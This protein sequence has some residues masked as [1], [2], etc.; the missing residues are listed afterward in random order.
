MARS[1]RLLSPVLTAVLVLLIDDLHGHT[2]GHYG[3]TTEPR[4][5][6]LLAFIALI[7][8]T[9]YAA[10]VNESAGLSNGARLVRSVGAVGSAVVIIAL[11][12]VIAVALQSHSA[13]AQH[14]YVPTFDLGLTVVF[15]APGLTVLASA[16]HRSLTI[17]GQQERVI[18]LVGDEERERLLR[19]VLRRPERPS[20]VAAT[21]APADVVPAEGRAAPLEEAIRVQRITLIVMN[22]EAQALDD[23]V[24]QA[25]RAHAQGVRIRTLSLYY[26]EWLG[27][28]PLSELER[29]ALLFD[30]NEIHRP[31]Y[32][33]GKRFLDVVLAIA[34]LPVLLVAMPL[35]ALVNLAGN[36]G[37]LF[38]HQE[39][40]G[41]DGTIFTIH[42]F[43]TMRPSDAPSSWTAPD[44]DRISAVG[45]TLR[46]LHVDELPQVWNVLR[47]ELSIVGPRP[48]Q[49][50]Y[51][52]QLSEVIPFYDT[53]HLVRPGI[54]GWAQVK[55]DYG[56][57]ELDALEKLQYEFYYL[58]H[59]SLALD[60]RI[61]GRTLRSIVGRQGR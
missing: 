47:R 1:T 22:R 16:T 60:L 12:E 37:S 46:R 21:L 30:I 40:V 57:T 35:V 10:G 2:L 15:L 41:K 14:L 13:G 20:V 11:V 34:G 5:A 45:R 51:V 36:R 19:D 4:F 17:Q 42:K 48:E 38:Y 24:S 26:D 54:T 49:P 8:I 44:D 58:R 7:W 9:T 52:S 27:K 59:Q 61:I 53:R 3:L 33:R 56:A 29:I 55:Y 32:A 23:I 31:V 39:R 6:W 18:A 50:H 43:R 25:A 28:L